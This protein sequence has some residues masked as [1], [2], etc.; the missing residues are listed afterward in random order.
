MKSLLI[1]L[2]GDTHWY[3]ELMDS[4]TG[5]IEDLFWKVALELSLDAS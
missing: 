2:T 1:R 3:F 5:S 4:G